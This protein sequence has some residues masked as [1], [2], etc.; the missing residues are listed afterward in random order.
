MAI[1]GANRELQRQTNQLGI[2]RGT[3]R[4]QRQ[5]GSAKQC[6]WR[7][8][9]WDQVAFLICRR[10]MRVPRGGIPRQHRPCLGEQGDI[11]CRL[12]VDLA[13]CFAVVLRIFCCIAFFASI[14]HYRQAVAHER[15]MH[16]RVRVGCRPRGEREQ[17]DQQHLEES[18]KHDLEANNFD[19]AY[20]S[21]APHKLT[22]VFMLTGSS[23][24]RQRASP[25]IQGF[26]DVAGRCHKPA[27][28]SF[29]THNDIVE[30]HVNSC[31]YWQKSRITF[32]LFCHINATFT[33]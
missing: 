30:T 10:V 24:G 23:S 14:H 19:A 2:R 16:A 29:L 31:L 27:P 12:C 25:D 13:L 32:L 7:A 26:E 8:Q 5:R 18:R 4:V 15:I 9:L 20:A 17:A 33:P 22:Q 3:H 6:V 11:V 1:R 28:F 21:G